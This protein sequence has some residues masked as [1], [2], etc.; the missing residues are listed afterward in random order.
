MQPAPTATTVPFDYGGYLPT[1]GSTPSPTRQPTPRPSPQP[2][3]TPVSSFTYTVANYEAQ[4]PDMFVLGA[5]PYLVNF[6]VPETGA[7]WE[8]C[9][10]MFEGSAGPELKVEHVAGKKVQTA[11]AVMQY[12]PG[13]DALSQ[14]F[15]L[16]SQPWV[17]I[18]TEGGGCPPHFVVHGERQ[19]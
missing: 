10:V 9:G 17:T 14:G 11:S 8:W 1:P 2:L 18:R 5:E 3:P 12:V 4:G 6:T 19:R 7:T 16:V 13:T 15:A